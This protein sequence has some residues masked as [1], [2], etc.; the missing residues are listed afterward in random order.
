MGYYCNFGGKG[1]A[2]DSVFYGSTRRKFTCARKI[3]TGDERRNKNAE[4]QVCAG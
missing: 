3:A 2:V 1:V 4:T